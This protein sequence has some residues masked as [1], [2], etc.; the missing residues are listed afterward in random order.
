MKP[1]AISFV[2]LLVACGNRAL[3]LASNPDGGAIADLAGASCSDIETATSQWLDAHLACQSPSDCTWTETAC[4]LP[5]HC[6]SYRAG[7]S[8]PYLDALRAAWNQ[9][10]LFCIR[11]G[12]TT[13]PKASPPPPACVG[14]QCF[15][16]PR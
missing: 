7:A 6:G 10:P 11:N 15:T 13:C 5:A 9:S 4:G 2:L 16:P 14:G 12:C 8:G 3:P 1:A